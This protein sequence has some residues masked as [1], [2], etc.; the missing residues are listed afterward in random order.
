MYECTGMCA[1]VCKHASGTCLGEGMCEYV[2]C[3]CI[4]MCVCMGIRVHCAQMSVHVCICVCTYIYMHS[5]TPDAST[6]H[7][8][9]VRCASPQEM[10]THMTSFLII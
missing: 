4:G 8:S 5:Q 9:V 1:Q 6:L 7:T 3:V 10:L 2:A